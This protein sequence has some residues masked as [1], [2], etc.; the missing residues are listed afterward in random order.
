MQSEQDRP[1]TIVHS[2]GVTTLVALMSAHRTALADRSDTRFD[3]ETVDSVEAYL[4]GQADRPAQRP[5]RPT[6]SQRSCN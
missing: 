3:Q 6:E 5:H 4:L 1:M 2:L